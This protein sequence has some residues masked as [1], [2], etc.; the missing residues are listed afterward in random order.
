MTELVVGVF[1]HRSDAILAIE[2]LHRH[3]VKAGR[4]SVVTRQKNDVKAISR[5]TGIGKPQSGIGNGGLFGTA[6]E[7]G[8]GLNMIDDTAVAAGPAAQKLAGADMETDGL[9]VSLMSVG[10]PRADAE[11]YARHAEL[12]HIVV[13]VQADADDRG[14]IIELLEAHHT[15]PADPGE[16]R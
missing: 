8:V 11:R 1:G 16:A 13:I 10:I 5:D 7:I 2:S 12:E 15:L 9:V 6:R 14:P 4:I 3:G